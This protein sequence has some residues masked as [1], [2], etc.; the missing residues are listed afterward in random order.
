MTHPNSI[1]FIVLAYNDAPAL[2]E[3]VRNFDQSLSQCWDEYE[4]IIVDDGSRD[5]TPE[6]CQSLR[7]LY[8]KVKT[9]R[10]NV[11]LG[12]GAAFST[13]VESAQ[14]EWIGYTDGDAQ[15]DARDVI[16]FKSYIN[17][18]DVITGHRMQRADPFHRHWV[19]KVYNEL[20]S[21]VFGLKLKDTNSAL[22]IYRNSVLRSV[23]PLTSKGPFY[24]AEVLIKAQASGFKII[25]TPIRHLPRKHG[26]SRGIAFSSICKTIGGMVKAEFRPYMTSG[27]IS[28]LTFRILN[29]V[30]RFLSFF[31]KENF[32]III[33]LFQ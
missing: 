12:V 23:F 13:G 9:I 2:T 10:H 17:S 4:I 25:E 20:L 8:P 1:S 18:F 16:A 22:K 14:Y 28:R 32:P 30:H 27:F 26:T 19:S 11:N 5:S 21:V 7:L 31:M 29:T 24:D 3:L 15:Y 33:L 6:V